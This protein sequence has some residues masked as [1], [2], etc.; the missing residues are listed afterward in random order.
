MRE[1]LLWE[2]RRLQNLI[3]TC[4]DSIW[5]TTEAAMKCEASDDGKGLLVK[6]QSRLRHLVR[7][8]QDTTPLGVEARKEGNFSDGIGQRC[9]RVQIHFSARMDT[10][11]IVYK[12]MRWI[13]N[14][15]SLDRSFYTGVFG[16]KFLYNYTISANCLLM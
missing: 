10:S 12:T 13:P 4:P 6:W 7:Q 3:K 1:L 9:L 14:K 8:W 2:K 11:V 16:L 15:G 5:M